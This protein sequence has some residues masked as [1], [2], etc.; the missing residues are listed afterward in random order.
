[1]ENHIGTRA[2]LRA[3][4]FR[5]KQWM[6]RFDIFYYQHIYN[7]MN[8]HQWTPATINVGM[9][10]VLP[11]IVRYFSGVGSDQAEP[12]KFECSFN[13]RDRSLSSIFPISWFFMKMHYSHYSYLGI[14]NSI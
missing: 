5:Q 1:M 9:E 14:L 12:D 6:H 2:D 11:V 13:W 4:P 7:K 10:A 8:N 3:R